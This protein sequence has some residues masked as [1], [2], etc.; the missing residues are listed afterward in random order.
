MKPTP[1][2]FGETPAQYAARIREDYVQALNAIDAPFVAMERERFEAMHGAGA[3]GAVHGAGLVSNTTKVADQIER[4]EI[5]RDRVRVRRMKT[6]IHQG[7][8]LLADDAADDKSSRYR[9]TFITL[10][11]RDVDGWEPNHIQAFQRRVRDWFRRR[12]AQIR[13]VWVAELQKRG[14]LHYHMLVWV[15]R[16]YMLPK[17][18]KQGWWPHGATEIKQAEHA[19]SYI[20]KYA[21]KTTAEQSAKYPAGARMHGVGGLDVERRRHMRYWQAPIAV[22][23]YLTGRADIRKCLGGYVDKYTG[24]FYRSP[25]QVTVTGDGRVFAWRYRQ[26][27]EGLAA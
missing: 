19:V 8:R 26:L 22:R 11:Y 27:P 2:V 16:R 10:T 13:Y 23:D 18:D 21:S 7:A 17:P 4:C 20:A 9:K 5:H 3:A 25:W 15:P 24:V 6:A 14:A 1:L 12:G